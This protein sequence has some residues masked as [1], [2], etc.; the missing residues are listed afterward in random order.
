MIYAGRQLFQFLGLI[1]IYIIIAILYLYKAL[2]SYILRKEI[3]SFKSQFV[4]SDSIKS[5][6][7]IIG[8]LFVFIITFIDYLHFKH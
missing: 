3:P 4:L 6:S 2:R 1:I 7:T 8:I 5:F